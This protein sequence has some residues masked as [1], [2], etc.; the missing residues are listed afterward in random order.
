M[1]LC[2]K[3]LALD[4]IV[5]RVHLTRYSQYDF[6]LWNPA[7]RLVRDTMAPLE[8]MVASIP[9]SSEST[10]IDVEGPEKVQSA[11]RSAVRYSINTAQD[12]GH[13]IGEMR[14][15]A[16]VTAEYIFL[17]QALGLDLDQSREPLRRWLLSNQNRG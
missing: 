12:D 14:S 4:M 7:R 9:A 13:W 2:W 6:M 5:G 15:N 3:C 11:L 1:H 17:C 16:T 10:H 8:K